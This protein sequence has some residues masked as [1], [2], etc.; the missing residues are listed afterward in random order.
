M[1]HVKK[2]KIGFIIPI[3]NALV[4]KKDYLSK[5]MNVRNAI[6]LS[7]TVNNASNY[8]TIKSLVIFAM[9]VINFKLIATEANNALHVKIRLK[10]VILATV[11]VVRY[12]ALVVKMD[13]TLF[14]MNARNVRKFSKTVVYVVKKIMKMDKFIVIFANKVLTNKTLMKTVKP[15][16]WT[17]NNM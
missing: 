4:V 15:V 9:R 6:K 10:T 5:V 13:Y 16:F 3:Y 1:L 11:R 12:N 2:V 7:K 14:K 8:K 17:A